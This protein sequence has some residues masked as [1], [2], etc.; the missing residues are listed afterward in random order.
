MH[1]GV[2]IKQ[3]GT[4]LCSEHG[5]KLCLWREKA[6]HAPCSSGDLEGFLEEAALEPGPVCAGQVQKGRRSRSNGNLK[7][8]LS[9]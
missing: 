7:H 9:F 4:E 5:R 6:E 1:S 8:F 2:R 3:K